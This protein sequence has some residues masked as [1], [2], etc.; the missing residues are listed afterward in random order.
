MENSSIHRY[1]SNLAERIKN[2]LETRNKSLDFTDFDVEF[3]RRYSNINYSL[4][5]LGSGTGLLVNRLIKDFHRIV[6]VEKYIEFSNF[7][8]KSDKIEIINADLL[9]FEIID[10]FNIVTVFGVM[11]FFSSSEAESIY[12]K[13]FDWICPN[14]KLIIKNQFGLFEDVVVSGFSEELGTEYFSN[15][16]YLHSELNLLKS[17]GYRNIEY[18]DI[19]PKESTRWSNTHFYTIVCEK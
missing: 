8:L 1:Y 19:Y 2:P 7:I 9:N 16:R 14:G 4:L 17:L 6:A 15:Y 3:V 13:I 12:K 10:K 5:D 18:F 11:N